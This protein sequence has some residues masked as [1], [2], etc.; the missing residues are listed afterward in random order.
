MNEGV[1]IFYRI[2]YAMIVFAE[3][4]LKEATSIEK[5]CLVLKKKCLGLSASEVYDIL[6]KSFNLNLKAIVSTRLME[7][8]LKKSQSDRTQ[9]YLPFIEGTSHILSYQDVPFP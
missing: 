4:E 5:A 7:S 3:K 8:R 1:K 9:F 2:Y 6:K